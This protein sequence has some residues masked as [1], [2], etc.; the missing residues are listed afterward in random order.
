MK[1]TKKGENIIRQMKKRKEEDTA[2][3]KRKLMNQ[4][5]K[6]I[7]WLLIIGFDLLK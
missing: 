6:I 5:I 3:K 1:A 7:S 2:G 4:N